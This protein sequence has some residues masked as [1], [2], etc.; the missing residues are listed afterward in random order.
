MKF[1]VIANSLYLLLLYLITCIPASA[2]YDRGVLVIPQGGSVPTD[3]RKIASITIGN[4]STQIHCD[5][6]DDIMEAKQK[7]KEMK[8]NL[9][10]IT[11]L[12]PPRFISSCF[13]IKADVLFTDSL[14]FYIAKFLPADKNLIDTDTSAYARLFIY[15]LADTVLF[16]PTYDLYL[17]DSLL[18]RIKPKMCQAYK[19]PQ[20]GMYKLSVPGQAL[21]LNAKKDESYYLRCGSKMGEFKQLPYIEFVDKETGKKEYG[22]FLHAKKDMDWRYL[23]KYH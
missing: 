14:D 18:Y 3:A 21:M 15:R 23:Y 12:I 10:R 6:D 2:Q 8:G 20:T 9:V 19:I 11:N 17:N 13:R 16:T 5:Y 7:A 22:N 1:K 4:N